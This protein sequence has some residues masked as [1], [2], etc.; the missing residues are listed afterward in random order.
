MFGHIHIAVGC[1]A[2]EVEQVFGAAGIRLLVESPIEVTHRII[3]AFGNPLEEG[4]QVE[5]VPFGIQVEPE[6]EAGRRVSNDAQ[7][8]RVAYGD[9]SL[10]DFLVAVQVLIF[11][12]SVDDFQSTPGDDGRLVEVLDFIFTLEETVKLFELE[13]MSKKAAIY[14]TKKLTAMNGQYLSELPLKKILPDAKPFFVKDGLVTEEWFNNAAN[15]AYFEKLVDVVRVRVKTLQEVADA[16][17]YFFK[18]VE[19]YDEKGVAKHFKA[20]NIPVLEQCIAAIKADDVYDLASTEAAYNK[21]A[22]D[23]GLALGKV[24]HP[25]R[26]A[27]TG[28]TV[29]PGMFDVMVLLGKERTLARLEKAVEFIKSL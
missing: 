18:D 14:D 7:V 29:S 13:Q 28:R 21:I 25:T 4:R 9:A 6:A 19:E 2:V 10:G 12:P 20:E 26:L 5:S 24:I 23:N 22:A 17:T 16:S 8:A 15:E 11:R 27:L 1:R 3:I